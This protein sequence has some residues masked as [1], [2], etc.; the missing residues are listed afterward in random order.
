M[1]AYLPPA[2]ISSFFLAENFVDPGAPKGILADPI[3]PR[4]GELLSIE[5]GFDPTD[6]AVLA[7]L[8][9]KRKT[10][11]AVMETG[12]RYQDVTHLGDSARSALRQETE[13]AL[14]HLV[15]SAQ[16]RLERDVP[17]LDEENQLAEVPVYW[18]NIARG[19]DRGLSI[20]LSAQVS[21]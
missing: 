17:V 11:A 18:R 7:A 2:G 1:P 13:L 12:Q 6:A 3:D 14:K 21:G 20:P 19:E 15:D 5:R 16:I 4:T 9:I 8:A 10:G